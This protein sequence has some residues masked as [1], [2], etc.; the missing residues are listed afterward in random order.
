MSAGTVFL[1]LVAA[2]F[3]GGFLLVLGASLG[4]GVCMWAG[5]KLVAFLERKGLI[6]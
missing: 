1:V 4:V 2:A 6:P 5:S 3:F